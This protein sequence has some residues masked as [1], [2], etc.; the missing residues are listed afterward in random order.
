[1]T[2]LDLQ[3]MAD[4]GPDVLTWFDLYTRITDP[5]PTVNW[6]HVENGRIARIRS[7]STSDH[8]SRRSQRRDR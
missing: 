1:M 8:C 7:P 6:S 3:M 5:L 2:G 4:E